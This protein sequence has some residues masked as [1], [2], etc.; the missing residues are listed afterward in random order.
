MTKQQANFFQ[1][2]AKHYEKGSI[3]LISNRSFTKLQDSK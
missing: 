3:I 1:I 2:A